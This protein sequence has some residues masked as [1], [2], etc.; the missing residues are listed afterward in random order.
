ER[1]A[2]LDPEAKS[3]AATFE[4]GILFTVQR[5]N[6]GPRGQSTAP[7]ERRG[8]VLT[9]APMVATRRPRTLAPIALVLLVSSTSAIGTSVTTILGTG[10]AGFSDA[11]INNPYG[12]VIGPDHAL[13]FCDLDN[14]RIRRVDTK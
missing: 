5:S 12:L 13:Y 7:G 6:D 10:A 2:G 1:D 14:Q 4:T 3:T 11:Q 8:L 9:W